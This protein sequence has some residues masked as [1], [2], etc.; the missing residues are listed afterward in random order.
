MSSITSIRFN[1]VQSN[2]IKQSQRLLLWEQYLIYSSSSSS[3]SAIAY[4]KKKKKEANNGDKRRCDHDIENT[5][6]VLVLKKDDGPQR[7]K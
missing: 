2:P 3:S 1:S 4:P 7:F 5:R 6:Q